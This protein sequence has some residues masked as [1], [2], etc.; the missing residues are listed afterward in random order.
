MARIPWFK[1][2]RKT[3][4]VRAELA[5]SEFPSTWNSEIEALSHLTKA[6]CS[7]SPSLLAWKAD[8]QSYDE[9]VP[10]GYKLSISMEKLP[11]S[12]PSESFFSSQ[13][14]L[15]ERDCLRMAFKAAWL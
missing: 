2:A 5:T 1:T 6:R 3:P 11:G 7:S 4:E 9:W 8:K 14:P 12:D 13:M 15:V 10:G